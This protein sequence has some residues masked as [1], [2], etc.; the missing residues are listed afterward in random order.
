MDWK[1]TPYQ[2][3]LKEDAEA[4]CKAEHE[5]A[6]TRWLTGEADL[7]SDEGW[8]Y[9]RSVV[10]RAAEMGYLCQAWP[11]EFGGKGH[12]PVEQ[13]IFAEVAG[14]YKVPAI[15]HHNSQVAFVIMNHGTEDQKKRWLPLLAGGDVT[16]AELYSEPN[17]GSDLASLTTSAVLQGDDYVINGSKTWT[18]GGHHATHCFGLVRTDPNQPRHRGLSFF[19]GKVGEGMQFR[20]VLQMD[21]SHHLNETFIDDFHIT[22]EEIIGEVNRGW[23]V[24]QAGR[25]IARANMEGIASAKRDV[26]ELVEFCNDTSSGGKLLA[27]NAIWRQKLADLAIGVESMR[28]FAY[29]LCWHQAKGADVGAEAAACGYSSNELQQRIAETGLELMGLYGPIESGSP[30][31]PLFGKFQSLAQWTTAITIAGGTTE[32][33]KNVITARGLRLPRD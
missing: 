19:I 11:E 13:L 31:A 8:A 5:R 17:S 21:G 27:E 7:H 32:I 20:P 24:M 14:Y 25:S 23:Y 9:H 1:F 2:Q 10:K 4:F 33:R 30:R 26:E 18:T 3:G 15:P 22:K 6:P 12:G 28:C 16:W 29:N